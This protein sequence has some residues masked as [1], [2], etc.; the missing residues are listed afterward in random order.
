MADEHV[1]LD[2]FESDSKQSPIYFDEL[3]DEI[4]AITPDDVSLKI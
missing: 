2:Y 4:S 1:P 3:E